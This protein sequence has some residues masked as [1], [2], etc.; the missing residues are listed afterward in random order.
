MKLTIT[1]IF[2]LCVSSLVFGQHSTYYYQKVSLFQSLPNTENE[3]I[4]LGD[5]ITDGCEWGELYGN[6]NIKNRGISGDVT[7]GVLDRLDE[8]TESSPDKVF[9]MVGVN[10]LARGVLVDEVIENMKE[11]I[12]KIKEASPS[13]EI[14][15]Q[16]ILP[17]NPDFGKFQKHMK[18][19]EEIKK[20]NEALALMESAKV[21]Y[22]DL[23]SQFTED[24]DKLSPRY[25]N[26]GLHL[27]VGGYNKWKEIIDPYILAK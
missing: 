17:V 21:H 25:T 13:T 11:I 6:A 19:I 5:S 22:V 14:Y 3:I 20:V 12:S 1:Y 18:K 23:Y 4:L 27:T 24:I 8:V 9:I 10:D 15:I 7:Q 26:E 16:S 2:I